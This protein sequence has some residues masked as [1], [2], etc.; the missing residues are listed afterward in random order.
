[1]NGAVKTDLVIGG[2]TYNITLGIV[3]KFPYK[4]LLGINVL[5]GAMKAII[6]LEKNTITPKNGF[7]VKIE[8]ER[9]YKEM[10]VLG[11]KMIIPAEKVRYLP[12][13]AAKKSSRVYLLKPMKGKTENIVVRT[14]ENRQTWKDGVASVQLYKGRCDDEQRGRFGH[15]RGV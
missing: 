11:K 8:A 5:R 15:N 14:L 7:A 2:K 6:N 1:M 13:E 4:V 3:E 9:T 10:V 12:M